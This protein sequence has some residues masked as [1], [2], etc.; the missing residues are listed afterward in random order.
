M[1]SVGISISGQS[2]VIENI[3]IAQKTLLAKIDFAV[4]GAGI[5]CQ[6]YA[7]LNCPVDTG[8]LRNSI[9]YNNTGNYSCTVN[10]NVTYA[11][12]VEFGTRRM[13][14]QPFLYPA[15]ALAMQELLDELRAA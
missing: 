7:K 2:A 10:T 4:Q 11:P 5:A 1:S 13:A 12:Y 8:R 15:Y 14:A 9:L 6:K 3:N